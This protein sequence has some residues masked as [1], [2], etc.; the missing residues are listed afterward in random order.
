MNPLEELHDRW[1]ASVRNQDASAVASLLSIDGSLAHVPVVFT[2]RNATT[3]RVSPIVVSRKSLEIIKM[4][5]EAGADVNTRDAEGGTTPL[6]GCSYEVG[7]YLIEQGA[8]IDAFGYEEL[9]PLAYATYDRNLALVEHLLAKGA[10]VNRAH[11]TERITPLHWAVRR[12]G[13]RMIRALLEAGADPLLQDAKGET[14][15]DWAK[16]AD[17]DEEVIQALTPDSQ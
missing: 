15:L 2:R 5:A 7:T 17:R 4:L 11:P 8:D 1:Q 13:M 12:C 3:Y 9:T 16:Q 14:P 6:S 10:K